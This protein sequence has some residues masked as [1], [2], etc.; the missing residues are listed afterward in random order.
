MSL[1]PNSQQN[2]DPTIPLN[3]TTLQGYYAIDGLRIEKGYRAWAHELTPDTTPLEAGLRF[4]LAW[5]KP[6]TCTLI[7]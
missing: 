3:F 6:G 4:T 5:D 2:L 7:S 1:Y